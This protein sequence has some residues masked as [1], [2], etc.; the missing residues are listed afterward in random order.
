MNHLM[1]TILF[2]RHRA[3]P[4]PPKTGDNH[5]YCPISDLVHDRE[6]S[7]KL[8]EFLLKGLDAAKSTTIQLGGIEFEVG[9][10]SID[11]APKIPPNEP[12]TAASGK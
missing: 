8:H 10:I 11:P 9:V 3:G 5:V 4:P 2:G 6:A 12:Q 7:R 1:R